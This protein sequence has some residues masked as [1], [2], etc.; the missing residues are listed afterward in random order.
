MV[1]TVER[2]FRI[3]HRQRLLEQDRAQQETSNVVHLMEQT[4]KLQD[5]LA[6]LRRQLD[7]THGAGPAPAP[8]AP[9]PAPAAE[10]A[11]P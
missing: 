3:A 1:D 4:R 10:G 8:S 6:D 11:T 9:Q 2:Q 5:Q 7:A